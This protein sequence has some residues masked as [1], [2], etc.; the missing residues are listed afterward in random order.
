MFKLVVVIFLAI[1][2]SLFLI[3]PMKLYISVWELVITPTST[4][5]CSPLSNLCFID[6]P[7]SSF[8]KILISNPLTSNELK[9]LKLLTSIKYSPL[10]LGA[11]V[12]IVHF[13]VAPVVQLKKFKI[14]LL[15]SLIVPLTQTFATYVI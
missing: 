2:P 1:D 5:A 13:P 8:I 4:E 10:A 14:V 11:F 7:N 6:W 15:L 12:F 3:V 9:P